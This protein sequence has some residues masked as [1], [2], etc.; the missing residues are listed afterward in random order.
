MTERIDYVENLL[1]GYGG[2]VTGLKIDEFNRS[3][4][5]SWIY[6]FQECWQGIA[7]EY[8]YKD[9]AEANELIHKY[10]D[11]PNLGELNLDEYENKKIL[12]A[13]LLI[14]YDRIVKAAINNT[15][16]WEAGTDLIALYE[17]FM[18]IC[19]H[20]NFVPMKLNSARIAAIAK[21]EK[22]TYKEKQKLKEWHKGNRHE[23]LKPDGTL[24][25]S[26]AAEHICY[27]LKL[28]GL[29]SKKVAQYMGEFEKEFLKQ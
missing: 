20:P 27:V 10:F 16:G 12:A 13:I 1:D 28:T 29:K 9:H 24:H 6:D 11:I 5:K 3:S 25:Q 2:T 22:T 8:L 18:K 19:D 7:W 26:D 15:S 17:I 14:Y 23:F 21:H 4:D